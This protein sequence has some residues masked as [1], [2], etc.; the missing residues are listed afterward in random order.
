MLLRAGGDPSIA[1]NSGKTFFD[2]IKNKGKNIL[3]LLFLAKD[4][5]NLQ[6]PSN[7][8]TLL[9]YAVLYKL[10]NFLQNLL[11]LKTDPNISNNI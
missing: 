3:K 9:H 6:D 1:N 2:L 8:Y 5:L 10:T 7:G 4:N 11:F